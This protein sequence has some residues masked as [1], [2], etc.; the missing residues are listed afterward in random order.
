MVKVVDRVEQGRP[1]A[2][3]GG[4]GRATAPHSHFEVRLAGRKYAPLLWLDG[5]RV[6]QASAVAPAAPVARQ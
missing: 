4:T 2:R 1:I 5:M 6:R 3:A